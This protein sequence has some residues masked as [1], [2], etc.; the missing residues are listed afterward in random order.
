M[1]CELVVS[2]IFFVVFTMHS[3]IIV[4]AL[5]LDCEI[6]FMNAKIKFKDVQ[7]ARDH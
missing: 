4:H 1:L 3:Q 2:Y 7:I 5:A 6:K